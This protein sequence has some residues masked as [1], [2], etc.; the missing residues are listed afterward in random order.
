MD[1][2]EPEKKKLKQ[3]TLTFGLCMPT[4]FET[5]SLT[6]MTD[7]YTSASALPSVP[8]SVT[9][10]SPSLSFDMASTSCTLHSIAVPTASSTVP[11]Q[12]HTSALP[13]ES[14]MT[15]PSP[16]V[17]HVV[18][19]TA[20]IPADIA[21][22]PS[23]PLSRPK[24]IAYPQS[25]FGKQRRS[26]SS[27]LYDKYKF[28]EYSV[29]RDA[30]F[31]NPCRF[32]GSQSGRKDDVMTLGGFRNWKKTERIADHAA[33]RYHKESVA[34]ALTAGRFVTTGDVLQQQLSYHA[35][36]VRDNREY[37]K[38]LARIALFCGKQSISL[39]GNNE[40]EGSSNKGNYLELVDLLGAE[41]SDFK[42]RRDRMASNANY[43]S[44]A[45][46]NSLLDAAVRCIL[47][48]I[49]LRLIVL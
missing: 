28:L 19:G 2:T 1:K 48:V 15:S 24:R 42:K 25:V 30:I 6:V 26:F 37:V 40:A 29:E 41:S 8:G 16:T 5:E 21:K 18:T 12:C 49:Q 14:D 46:Q 27:A 45:S 20:S 9:T 47:N 31:C 34:T 4:P 17:Q 7:T 43:L 13:S 36:I 11:S 35:E 3:M 39:R 38:S 32:F 22:L 44:S 33:T 10:A 23:D